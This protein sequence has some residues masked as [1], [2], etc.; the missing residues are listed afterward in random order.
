M[1]G[2]IFMAQHKFYFQVVREAASDIRKKKNSPL[3]PSL[4]LYAAHLVRLHHKT[5]IKKFNVQV[6]FYK[7]HGYRGIEYDY[8]LTV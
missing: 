7:I 2:V 8:F 6:H 3:R 5:D 4:P 1:I